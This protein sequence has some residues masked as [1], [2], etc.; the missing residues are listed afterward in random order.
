M[1]KELIFTSHDTTRCDVTREAT[2]SAASTAL[3]NLGDRLVGSAVN[4]HA[5]SDPKTTGSNRTYS[6]AS[7]VNMS[8]FR[9]TQGAR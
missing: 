4:Y 5:L 8:L 7:D 3:L 9:F 2:A 1:H 6:K